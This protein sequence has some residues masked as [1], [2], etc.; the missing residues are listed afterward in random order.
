MTGIVEFPDRRLVEQE[1]AEW[2]IR[3]DGRAK[4][5]ADEQKRL[6]EWLER[7]PAHRQELD[8]LAKLWGRINVL[9]ELT[10][11]LGQLDAPGRT[12]FWVRG[13]SGPRFAF[14]GFAAMVIVSLLAF[15]V[16]PDSLTRTNGLY[17]TAIGELQSI[18]LADGS[19]VVLNTNS[20][21]RV[22]YT[23]QYRDLQ[24]LQGEA[25]FVV[26]ENEAQPF[27][28]YASG[29]RIEAIGTAFDVRLRDG[30]VRVAVLE[31]KVALAYQDPVVAE[32]PSSGN[33]MVE[34]SLGT[35]EAG[36][37]GV[38]T[39][40][41]ETGVNTDAAAGSTLQQIETPNVERLLAW[42]LGTLAFSG[43]SLEA[44]VSE[45]SRYTT[46]H[47]EI[48][49]PAVRAIRIGGQVPVGQTDAMLAALEDNFGFRVERLS[50]D[51]VVL[52]A[53]RD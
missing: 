42:R 20:Q 3:L 4:P 16:G 53:A 5:S 40:G 39:E 11:P 28:V 2:L 43:E 36:Q 10:V 12:A 23:E 14:A 52:S 13:G 6:G 37:A 49:G 24:L 15:F 29:R 22:S 27:R 50:P 32:N 31:G 26:A 21:I 46:V 9:T 34:K 35:L 48:S 18:T 44:V 51:H 1:A 19:E 47:I 33:A 7:S 45:I 41:T 25:H 38:I 30:D 8:S 17:S